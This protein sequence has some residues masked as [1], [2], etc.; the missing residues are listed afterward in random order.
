MLFLIGAAFGWWVRR[1]GPLFA[2]RTFACAVA[3][4]AVAGVGVP[5]AAYL[6]FPDWMWGYYVNPRD[7]PA[8]VP[9]VIFVLY[10]A[11]FLL[12]YVAPRKLEERRPPAALSF[13]HRAMP[14]ALGATGLLWWLARP[15]T[16]SPRPPGPPP[17]E[18]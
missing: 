4:Y 12:G 6:R 1:D 13:F 11:P 18:A 8:I 15:R 14:V 16:L 5:V 2:T 17:K 7:V 9:V 10:A 3:A